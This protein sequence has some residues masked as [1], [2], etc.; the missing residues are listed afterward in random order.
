M[1]SKTRPFVGGGGGGVGS[2]TRDKSIK[3]LAIASESNSTSSRFLFIMVIL[4]FSIKWYGDFPSFCGLNG[5][6]DFGESGED[7]EFVCWCYVYIYI[8][9]SGWMRV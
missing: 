8:Y 4:K 5:I 9:S 3:H 7:V 6:F 1:H 2:P